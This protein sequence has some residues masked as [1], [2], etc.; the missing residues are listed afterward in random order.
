MS[1][2]HNKK[3]TSRIILILA[4]IFFVVIIG[5]VVLLT[6]LFDDKPI[7]N[8]R[9][10]NIDPQAA[11]NA[12][13]LVK[14]FLKEIKRSPSSANFT[15]KTDEF[16]V[17]SALFSRAVPKAKVKVNISKLGLLG[18]LSTHLPSNP[19]GQYLNVWVLVNPS[20]RGVSIESVRIGE[21]SIPGAFTLSSLRVLLDFILGDQQGSELINSINSVTM[22]NQAVTVNINQP[23]NL[24]LV[25]EK[26][27]DNIKKNGN[28]LAGVSEPKKVRHYYT[29]LMQLSRKHA[30]KRTVSLSD[31]IGPIFSE[32][33]KRSSQSNA[34]DENQAAI[35]AL[36]IYY[37]HSR[38]ELLVGEVTTEQMRRQKPRAK[39]VLADRR[40]LR[41]HFIY[42]A[43]LEIVGSK[44]SSTTIGELKELMDANQGGSGF[45]F[46]DLA[47]DMAGIEFA[48][49]ATDQKIG[50]WQTQNILSSNASEKVFFPSIKGL[51]EG[52]TESQFRR[53]YQNTQS[54]AYQRMVE[55]IYARLNTL[56]LYRAKK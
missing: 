11:Q 32:A 13:N 45:S 38:F 8:N 7:V 1:T 21:I 35:L 33:K 14:R 40:D 4:S 19:F 30:H 44:Q 15:V 3:K 20:Q 9:V 23:G 26:L 25:K 39:V 51:P 54:S 43:A 49:W 47:A 6:F 36:A 37:G 50:A 2:K 41:L 16:D 29:L 22:D 10:E 52:L 28:L 17:L 56:E 53:L 46:A 18:A 34:A 5:L 31:F 12:K 55:K 48:R 42:S 27:K 24:L